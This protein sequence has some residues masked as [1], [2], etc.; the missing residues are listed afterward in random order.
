MSRPAQ[1]HRF[2][3]KFYKIADIAKSTND[4]Y[5]FKL[6]DDCGD[7]YVKRYI[8]KKGLSIA[9][10]VMTLH[11]DFTYSFQVDNNFLEIVYIKSGYLE[12]FDADKQEYHRVNA[13]EYFFNVTEKIKGRVRQPKDET[14]GYLSINIKPEFIH[15]L[16]ETTA[17]I[18]SKINRFRDSCP[19]CP[20]FIE[21]NVDIKILLDK[22]LGCSQDDDTIHKLIFQS[23]VIELITQCLSR[24]TQSV[25]AEKS[26][27]KL[28]SSDKRQLY[29]AKQILLDNMVK[30][31]SI[32]LLSKNLYLNS[33]KLKLGF[34]ALFSTTL[35]GYLRDIR[36]EKA[37]LLLKSTNLSILSIALQIGYSNSSSFIT[38]FKSKYGVTPKQYRKQTYELNRRDNEL[39]DSGTA[40]RP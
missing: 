12:I 3:T 9:I 18:I 8:Y 36:L 39:P 28:N 38:S 19:D 14:V 17:D 11:H 2:D 15:S 1:F 26:P 16:G 33:C 23:A 40:L 13:G 5:E 20:V 25:T 27:V 7:G 22:M 31:P 10:S 35:Y 30:P 29:L 32:E 24:V 21:S 6:L 34:K 37:Q 4:Y